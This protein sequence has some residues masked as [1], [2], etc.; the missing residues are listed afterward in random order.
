MMSLALHPVDC[1]ALR[2]ERRENAIATRLDSIIIDRAPLR[3]L[4]GEASRGR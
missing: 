3:C 2:F 1:F 4:E